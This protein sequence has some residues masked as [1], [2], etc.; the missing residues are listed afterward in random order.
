MPRWLTKQQRTHYL[1]RIKKAFLLDPEIPIGTMAERFLGVSTKVVARAR[2]E[3][4]EELEHGRVV[5]H[6]P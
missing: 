6:K 5:Q 4:L 1:V 2:L 3:A